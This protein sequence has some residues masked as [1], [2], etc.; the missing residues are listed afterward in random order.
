MMNRRYRYEIEYFVTENGG[1]KRKQ[2]KEIEFT[3]PKSD[4]E[5]KDYDTLHKYLSMQEKVK[6][7]VSII[8]IKLIGARN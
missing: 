5:R 4:W 8:E 6:C 7:E 2:R 3:K 1:S